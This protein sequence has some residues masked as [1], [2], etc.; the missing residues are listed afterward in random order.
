MFNITYFREVQIKTKM[1]Y[2]L[3]S[4][5]R[6]TMTKSTNNK[7]WRGMEKREPS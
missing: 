2:H 6:V 1:M 5:I 3:T 4:L 7:Y